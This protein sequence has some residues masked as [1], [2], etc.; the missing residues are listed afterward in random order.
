MEFDDIVDEITNMIKGNLLLMAFDDDYLINIK[1]FLKEDNPS[2]NCI[3]Y[4]TL[5]Y[6]VEEAL[7][8]LINYPYLYDM[9]N[10]E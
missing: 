2:I 6:F 1:E 7:G 9:R 5:V 10:L 4:W 8:D 3:P